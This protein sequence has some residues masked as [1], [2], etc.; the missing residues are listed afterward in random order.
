MA[1]FYIV[2]G[3]TSAINSNV[4]DTSAMSMYWEISLDGFVIASGNAGVTQNGWLVRGLAPSPTA[5]NTSLVEITAPV[6]ALAVAHYVARVRYEGVTYKLPFRLSPDLGAI[7]LTATTSN[8][9]GVISLSWTALSNFKRYRVYQYSSLE[10]AVERIN[11]TLAGTINAGDTPPTN[12]FTRLACSLTGALIHFRVASSPLSSGPDAHW[13]NIASISPHNSPPLAASGVTFTVVDAPTRQYQM[14]WTDDNKPDDFDAYVLVAQRTNYGPDYQKTTD[15]GSAL[16]HTF[17]ADWGDWIYSIAIR[18]TCGLLTLDSLL[19]QDGAAASSHDRTTPP[20]V[21]SPP[22]AVAGDTTNTVS[23]SDPNDSDHGILGYHIYVDGNTFYTI[24]V[25]TLNWVHSGL[26]NGVAHTYKV[27]AVDIW[28]NESAK[29]APSDPATPTDTIAPPSPLFLTATTQISSGTPQVLLRWR[30]STVASAADTA[31]FKVYSVAGSSGS[32]VYTAVSGGETGNGT[33]YSFAITPL[34]AG[35]TYRY[36]VT[37]FDEA[38]NESGYS[39]EVS[40]IARA[41]P[42]TLPTLVLDNASADNS[43]LNGKAVIAITLPVTGSLVHYQ[44]YTFASPYYLPLETSF[45]ANDVDVLVTVRGLTNGSANSVFIT[46]QNADGFATAFVSKSV[47][48]VD[49]IA[50]LPPTNFHV[51]SV[52]NGSVSL[53]WTPSLSSDI[54][55]YRLQ[56]YTK[57]LDGNYVVLGS[58]ITLSSSAINTNVTSLTNGVVVYFALA[59]VD[60]RPST[61]NVSVYTDIVSATPVDITIPNAPDEAPAVESGIGRV[62]ITLPPVVSPPA[63]LARYRIYRDNS[64]LVLEVS[65]TRV[66]AAEV[67]E[68]ATVNIG[69]AYNYRYAMVDTSG[70]QSSLSPQSDSVTPVALEALEAW[71]NT[72]ETNCERVRL[73][74]R[75][76]FVNDGAKYFTGRV[77]VIGEPDSNFVDLRFGFDLVDVDTRDTRTV[78]NVESLV[79]SNTPT[80]DGSATYELTVIPYSSSQVSVVTLNRGYFSDPDNNETLEAS[81]GLEAAVTAGPAGT[82]V[83]RNW[84][85][86][87]NGGGKSTVYYR[88]RVSC[89]ENDQIALF[90]TGYQPMMSVLWES[91]KP[92]SPGV[93]AVD[94]P[95]LWFT[96][97]R[98]IWRFDGAME[99]ASGNGT[100]GVEAYE[101]AVLE[102]KGSRLYSTLGS[103]VNGARSIAPTVPATTITASGFTTDPLLGL[104]TASGG[105]VIGTPAAINAATGAAWASN[106]DLELGDTAETDGVLE[107]RYTI[108]SA[109]ANAEIHLSLRACVASGGSFTPQDTEALEVEVRVRPGGASEAYLRRISGTRV[110]LGREQMFKLPDWAGSKI[111]AGGSLELYFSTANAANR[112]RAEAYFTPADHSESLLLGSAFVPAFDGGD[113]AV[114]NVFSA[115]APV[116][117]ANTLIRCDELFAASG[118]CHLG[119]D[120]GDAN[121]DG[122]T[123][124]GYPS[125]A[126]VPLASGGAGWVADAGANAV[127][128]T[129]WDATLSGGES[130]P[131]ATAT[132][133]QITLSAPVTSV[134]RSALE[135]QAV[136]PSYSMHTLLKWQMK[137]ITG[138]FYVALTPSPVTHSFED[139]TAPY[140]FCRRCDGDAGLPTTPY[141]TPTLLVCFSTTQRR[142]YALLRG[143]DGTLTETTLSAFASPSAFEEWSIE[144]N[145]FNQFDSSTQTILVLRRAGANIGSEYRLP[146]LP[147]AEHG[148]GLYA[149]FGVRSDGIGTPRINASRSVGSAIISMFAVYGLPTMEPIDFSQSRRRRHFMRGNLGSVT[150]VSL[151]GQNMLA[152]QTDKHGWLYAAPDASNKLFFTPITFAPGSVGAIF[153]SAGIGLVELRMRHRGLISAPMVP[154]I[155]F[156]ANVANGQVSEPLTDWIAAR[157]LYTGKITPLGGAAPYNEILQFDLISSGVNVMASEGSRVVLCVDLPANCELAGVTENDVCQET[158]S[159]QVESYE[160]YAGATTYISRADNLWCR[161]FESYRNRFDNPRD[162]AFL[163][164]RVRARSHAGL[165]S[166]VSPL[167]RTLSVD[168]VGPQARGYTAPPDLML[169]FKATVRSVTVDVQAVDGGSGLLA[170]RVLRETDSGAITSTPWLPWEAFLLVTPANTARYTLYLYGNAVLG[171]TNGSYDGPRKLWAQVMDKVGNVTETKSVSVFAQNAALVDTLPPSGSAEWADPYTGAIPAV[172]NASEGHIKLNGFD[173]V[174]GVKDARIR[175]VGSLTWKDWTLLSSYRRAAF[176]DLFGTNFMDGLARVEVQFRDW[177]GTSQQPSGFWDVLSRGVAAGLLFTCATTWKAPADTKSCVYLGAIKT[178]K[179]TNMTLVKDTSTDATDDRYLVL[180]ESVG[181]YGRTVKLRASDHTTVT[182]NGDVWSRWSGVGSEPSG[183]VYHI[184]SISGTVIFDEDLPTTPDFSIDIRRESAQLY[185]WDGTALTRIADIG[186]RGERILLSLLPIGDKLLMGGGKGYLWKTDGVNVFGPIFTATDEEEEALPISVL[187]IHQFDAE[188]RIGED[189]F[190]YLATGHKLRLFRAALS[191]AGEGSEWSVV[192]GS[193]GISEGEGDILSAMSAYDKLWL[194]T[195]NGTIL[196]YGRHAI[197]SNVSNL[198]DTWNTYTLAAPPFDGD[199]M[200]PRPVKALLPSGGEIYAGIGDRPEIWRYSLQHRPLPRTSENWV[201]N[202]F[203]AALVANSSPWQFYTSTPTFMDGSNPNIGQK[204]DNR[205]GMFT[206][207]T[208]ASTSGLIGNLS[209]TEPRSATGFR[210]M[211]TLRGDAGKMAVFVAN[212]GSDWSDVI[213]GVSQWMFDI[214]MMQIANSG[215]G[216][217]GFTISDGRYLLEVSLSGTDVRVQ[218]GGNTATAGFWDDGFSLMSA[219]SGIGLASR[220]VYPNSAPSVIWNFPGTSQTTEVKSGPYYDGSATVVTTGDAQGWLA[221]GGVSTPTG[222]VLAGSVSSQHY[223]AGQRTSQETYVTYLKVQPTPIGNP[224][225]VNGASNSTIQVFSEGDVTLLSTQSFSTSL[226]TTVDRGS[227][228]YIRCRVRPPVGSDLRDA[229][230]RATWSYTDSIYLDECQWV[231]APLSQEWHITSTDNPGFQDAPPFTYVLEPS[232]EGQVRTLALEWTG[233]PEGS[234][235]PT[236]EIEFIAIASDFAAPNIMSRLTPVRVGVD[237]ERVKVWVGQHVDPIIDEQDFLTLPV[238]QSDVSLR[239]GKTDPE[240]SGSVWGYGT[241]RF[242]A[243]SVVPP[244]EEFE[245]GWTRMAR[246]PSAGGVQKMVHFLGSAVAITDGLGYVRRADEPQEREVKL[247]TYV[248]DREIWVRKSPATPINQDGIGVVRALDAVVYNEELILA[249]QQDHVRYVGEVA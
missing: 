136:R 245:T 53:A 49:T 164:M 249:G 38:N 65:K 200:T 91:E 10:D 154:K 134:G 62:F 209:I 1:D 146:L 215:T 92:V 189:P 101:A 41:S 34:T 137:T 228:L 177:G 104:F 57:N 227:K 151:L 97:K 157:D 135:L 224:R 22:T 28:G 30:K 127:W 143:T 95:D 191:N 185:R 4:T 46:G 80:F 195:S 23:W 67:F 14:N 20:P 206:G 79:L 186:G 76:E 218:S 229:K 113:F 158:L 214:E 213:D 233:L 16:T 161:L 180:S 37:S 190:V 27:S 226:P 44:A 82:F 68:D 73:H 119:I 94:N 149:A 188:E 139:G 112:V 166:A 63:D 96:G 5:A 204:Y 87:G 238:S 71:D 116:G 244:V 243:G 17:T 242:L 55:S 241:V 167:S 248:P 168:L 222:T 207:I 120:L 181:S 75:G 29:S 153:G 78:K 107:A 86:S 159:L 56:R 169:P 192:T 124:L 59:A 111:S 141:N 198:L 48:P 160:S 26:T 54:G 162:G 231:E 205:I 85:L 12:E 90:P 77:N 197:Y 142:V 72:T 176:A 83:I 100:R 21:P 88:A 155:R 60:T 170:F 201:V 217:Q 173:A 106:T 196:S 52:A 125:A 140:L 225:I 105:V 211:I 114:R 232:W 174:S 33:T 103:T 47:A 98:T 89:E 58:P 2:P 13:S 129:L 32:E 6:T 126:T 133:E 115:F 175:A 39:N 237:G 50:P 66:D 11:G 246:L 199:P 51:T 152:G 42:P 138:E 171:A 220:R 202:D 118:I 194:G 223:T 102:I 147:P 216:R 212:D 15:L 148:E 128:T 179:F 203:T 230:I 31:K 74:V 45:V 144:V 123:P 93:P 19:F 40:V 117:S 163:Q 236:V 210:E 247:F 239:I 3:T 108:T 110:V 99:S 81:R 184:D 193:G 122:G 182:I 64:T 9:S 109:P 219:D 172:T 7:V 36:V 35:V 130:V 132:T 221:A 84:P 235:R 183:D 150:C 121:T 25:L 178:Q 8:D 156:Y 24:Q 69:T 131:A 61:P 187:H 240:E 208:S 18:D 43:A 70:N 145:T 165:I 234:M